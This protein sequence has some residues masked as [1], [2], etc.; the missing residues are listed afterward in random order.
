MTFK[1][2]RMICPAL[3]ISQSEITAVSF[4]TLVPKERF[5]MS[6][7]ASLSMSFT[8]ETTLVGSV[9]VR[10]QGCTNLCTPG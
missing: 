1:D 9:S 2:V 5:L 8:A 6:A 4:L 3:S 10:N 7:L